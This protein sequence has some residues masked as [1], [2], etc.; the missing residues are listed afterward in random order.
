METSTNTK[1]SLICD[2]KV[3][4]GEGIRIIE[5][6]RKETANPRDKPDKGC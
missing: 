5:K 6:T 4:Y 3:T 1:D 2:I